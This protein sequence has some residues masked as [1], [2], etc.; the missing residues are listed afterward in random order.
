LSARVYARYVALGDSSTEGLDDPIGLG[1]YRG[2]ADRLA[3]HVARARADALPGAEPLLYANLAVRGRR[4]RQVRDD[5][6]APALAMRPDLVTVFSGTNDVIRRSFALDE[7]V[8]DVRAMQ[9]ALRDTGATV[10]TI[11]LPDLSD[12]MPLAKRMRHKLA[13]FNE[14]VRAV[15]HDTGT[16]VVD[17]AKHPFACD[18]RFWSG[19]RLH[20]NTEGHTRI[21]AALAHALELPGSDASWADAL[22]P[23]TEPTLITR[24]RAELRWTKEHLIPWMWRH[25]RGRS[26]GDGIVAKRPMLEPMLPPAPADR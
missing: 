4:T 15:S 5:Q 3:A 21:A 20:A 17:L 16:I 24:V 26:S 25:V 7:V 14:A 1:R 9:Q 6:L 18:P 11:T 12:V 10:L 13:A 19:D 2:W 23:L 8:A 22:P